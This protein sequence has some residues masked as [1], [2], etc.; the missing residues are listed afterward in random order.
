MGFETSYYEN[1]G[2]EE[3]TR[4]FPNGDKLVGYMIYDAYIGTWHWFKM[5]G[6]IIKIVFKEDDTTEETVETN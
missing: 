3:C 2:H 1:A 5:N 6:E 4:R